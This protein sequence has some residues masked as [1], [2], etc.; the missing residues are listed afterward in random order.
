MSLTCQALFWCWG[1][2]MRVKEGAEMCH[3]SLLKE[4]LVEDEAFLRQ[5][6]TEERK[7]NHLSAVSVNTDLTVFD[8]YT[9]SQCIMGGY[10]GTIP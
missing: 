10:P 2:R 7:E 1:D 5:K 9:N 6:Q 8:N 3:K 4:N